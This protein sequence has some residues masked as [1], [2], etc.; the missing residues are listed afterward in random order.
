MA[1][2]PVV[3]EPFPKF[4]NPPMTA[5]ILAR[6]QLSALHQHKPHSVYT[7][8]EEAA[9]ADG[10]HLKTVLDSLVRTMLSQNTTD[11]TSLRAFNKLKATYSTWEEVLEA[12][13]SSV[14][15]AIREGGL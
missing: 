10:H 4:L 12:P 14:E 5:C 9:A 2:S 15:D 13:A 11:K 8:L 7:S 6:D 1:G 3:D